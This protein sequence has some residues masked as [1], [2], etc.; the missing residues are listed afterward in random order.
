[1]AFGDPVR[2]FPSWSLGTSAKFGKTV[3]YNVKLAAAGATDPVTG[4]TGIM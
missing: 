2:W 1:M 3:I 4:F